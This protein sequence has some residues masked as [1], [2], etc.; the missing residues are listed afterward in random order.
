MKQIQKACCLLNKVQSELLSGFW[1]PLYTPWIAPFV[2]SPIGAL[3]PQKCPHSSG[4]IV[5]GGR[6]GWSRTIALGVLGGFR[7]TSRYVRGGAARCTSSHS[8]CLEPSA[9][10]AVHWMGPAGTLYGAFVQCNWYAFCGDRIRRSRP[11]GTIF[12]LRIR[13]SRRQVVNMMVDREVDHM[14]KT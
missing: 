14:V 3:R 9:V 8:H 10:S 6:P 7:N 4:A 12:F 11:A 2:R 13:R 1:N 5:D